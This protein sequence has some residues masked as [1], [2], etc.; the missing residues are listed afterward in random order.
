[1][2]AHPLCGTRHCYMSIQSRQY[3][4]N[5]CNPR[6]DTLSNYFSHIHNEQE[7]SSLI[8]SSP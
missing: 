3:P 4:P 7:Q 2:L 5:Q 6:T 1:M 8:L